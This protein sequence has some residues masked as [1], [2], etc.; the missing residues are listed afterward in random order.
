MSNLI[1]LCALHH[2]IVDDQPERFTVA[3]LQE[4]KLRHETS[5]Q[6]KPANVDEAAR[7]LRNSDPQIH[8]RDQAQVMISS[9]GSVQAHNI[10]IKTGRKP[11]TVPLPVDAI[12]ANIP[13]RSYIEYLNSRYIDYRNNAIRRGIDRRPFFPGKLHTLINSHFG[14]RTNLVPQ[15]RFDE[16]VAFMQN[17]IDNTIWGRNSRNRNYHSF[18]EHCALVQGSAGGSPA[19]AATT[20]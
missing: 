16:V 14:A 9:P 11:P 2:R 13:M 3:V 19:S 8:A 1:L 12:G 10:T 18:A 4:M 15:D 7:R 17:A 5:A 20:A 6:P